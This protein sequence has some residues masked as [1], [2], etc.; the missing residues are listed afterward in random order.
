MATPARGV[1]QG[2]GRKLGGEAPRAPFGPRRPAQTNQRR[3]PLVELPLSAAPR[4]GH[5]APAVLGHAHG[6]VRELLKGPLQVVH[7][8][9]PLG[10]ELQSVVEV[11]VVDTSVICHVDHGTAHDGV[12]IS[13][14]EGGHQQVHVRLELPGLPELVREA[15]DGHVGHAEERVEPHA[16][17]RSQ[18]GLVL[19]LERALVGRKEG[20]ARVVHEVQARGP[21]LPAPVA[22]GVER[23]QGLDGV[24][25][26]PAAP[27]LLHVGG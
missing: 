4:A 8:A 24:Q 2:G 3:G 14:V 17:V 21:G 9:L 11:A 27:L 6:R 12:H 1:P 5:A 22:Q 25:E 15:L 13:R 26:H 16:K 18:L 19:G 10:R 20:A 7:G 23:L